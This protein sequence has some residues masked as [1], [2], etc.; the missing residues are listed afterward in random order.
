MTLP[1]LEKRIAEALDHATY[2]AG[3]TFHADHPMVIINEAATILLRL[4]REFPEEALPGDAP[5][6]YNGDQHYVWANG[7]NSVRAKVIEIITKGGE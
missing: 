6:Q 7:C 3:T 2:S 4:I 5:A 1:T